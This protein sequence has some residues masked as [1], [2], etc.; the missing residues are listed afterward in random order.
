[1]RK[2]DLF[3]AVGKYSHIGF[4]FGALTIGGFFLGQFIDK[5]IQSFPLFSI[6]FFLLG[7]GLGMYRFILM[8]L[9]PRKT[10]SS[11][12]EKRDQE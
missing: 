3:V 12:A 2:G 4:L 10:E 7:F 9:P 8:V 6:L 1:M 11:E 5:K